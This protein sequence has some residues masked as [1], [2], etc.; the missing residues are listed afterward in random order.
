MPRS[1]EFTIAST[2]FDELDWEDGSFAVLPYSG[3]EH[4][5]ESLERFGMMHP[6]WI[7]R[8][9]DAKAVIVD[10]FKRL[11]WLRSRGYE[12]ATCVVFAAGS[13]GTDVWLRRIEGKM[14]ESPLNLAEKAQIVARLAELSDAGGTW[15]L[16]LSRLGVSQRPDSIAKWVRLAACGTA[17]LEAAA[18]GEIC[19]RAAME[20]LDWEERARERILVIL[21][22]LRCSA[23]IQVEVIERVG[24]IAL[25]D[26]KT[27]T[28]VLDDP[29]WEAIVRDNGRNHREKT[30][31]LRDLLY[32]RRF[33]RLTARTELFREQAGRLRLPGAARLIPPPSFEGDQWQLEISF[34]SAS[35]LM[36]LLEEVRSRTEPESLS[37]V[38]APRS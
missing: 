12:K 3:S 20:L 8:R 2:G 26:G 10:G 11:R 35:E 28:A 18:A 13:E 17:L 1:A 24:E 23:S 29:D 36:T 15:R 37:E 25:R 6:P 7:L 34:S 19:E 38:M 14:F 16:L 31:D 21:R 33:P 9:T 5:E 22:E 4:L 27:L 30:R 32:R